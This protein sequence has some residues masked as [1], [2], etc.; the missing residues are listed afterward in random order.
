MI[1]RPPRSTRTDT[2]FPYTTLFRS[3]DS[4]WPHAPR[5]HRTRLPWRCGR[6]R[7][8]RPQCWG[9]LQYEGRAAP[10]EDAAAAAEA[11]NPRKRLR[12]ALQEFHH[13]V[14]RDQTR[15]LHD[16]KSVVW[17]KSVSARLTLGGARNFKKKKK[18]K[19]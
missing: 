16:R 18:K 6:L 11:Q 5:P 12:W 17:G 2:L 8:N 15:G 9:F 19:Y 13:S 7:Q 4:H 1:R 14:I 10:H 3:S